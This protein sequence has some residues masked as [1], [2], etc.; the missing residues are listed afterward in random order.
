MLRPMRRAT[1]LA[2]AAILVGSLGSPGTGSAEVDLSPAS[3]PEGELARYTELNR[4]LRSDKP[5]AEGREGMVV[6]TTGALA[7]RAGVEALRQGGSAADAALVTALT[8]VVLAAGS[9]VSFAGILSMVHYSAE[10]RKAHFVNGE[11]NTVLGETDPLTIPGVGPSGRTAL[12]P[13]FMAAVEAAHERFGRLPFESLFTPAVYFAREGFPLDS[14]L[15]GT[16]AF[17]RDVL[18]R[19]PATREIFFRADGSLYGTGDRFRQPQLA[20]TLERVA[21]RGAAHMYEGAWAERLVAALAAEGGKMTLED[22]ARY[23]ALV[24]KAKKARFNGFV[25]HGSSKPAAGG[26]LLAKTLRAL[27]K[28]DLVEL[29]HY[30]ESPETLYQLMRATRAAYRS[31]PPLNHSDAVLAVDA[32]GNVA[33]VLHSINTTAWGETGI[34]VDGVSIPDSAA[35]QQQR[36]R[37]AGPGNRLWTATY[38]MIV[39]KKR[40]PMLASSAIGSGLFEA[41]VQSALNVLLWGKAPKE[42]VDTPV[43]RGPVRLGDGGIGPQLVTSGDF[44]G[45]LLDRV[46]ARGIPI[47]ERSPLDFVARGYWIG[48][49]I[50]PAT[51]DLSGATTDLF[52][53]YALGF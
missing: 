45:D 5:P 42:A 17:R 15:A 49:S 53:G 41:T 39:T 32:E 29:G 4:S 33:A 44:A 16:M 6:G 26:G 50:D 47:E 12:V 37:A 11:Y 28:H 19:L 30:T 35:R 8:E 10:G 51:G 3:W 48:I 23:R 43:F 38:P 9:W 31:V 13:G 1:A 14:D 22:L 24:S 40:R 20:A 52:N 27:K 36:V 34:F 25:G 46:R 18:H 21:E 2:L 7:V